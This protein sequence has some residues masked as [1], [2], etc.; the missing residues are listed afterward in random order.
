M[1]STNTALFDRS[2]IV[3]LSELD[4]LP[5]KVVLVAV[6]EA[7]VFEANHIP[8]SVSIEPAEL[9]SGQSPAVG[10]IPS[11]ER[12][13]A[14]FSRIGLSPESHVVAYDDEGG[15]WAGRLIWTLDVIGHGRSSY[16]NGGLV[17][18]LKSGRPVQTGPVTPTPA[19]YRAQLD[20]TRLRDKEWVLAH[21]DDPEVQVWDARSPEE[22][23]GERRNALRNGHIPGARNLDWLEL[24]DP[25]ND[26]RL[27]PPDVIRNKL[28]R[29]GIDADKA[30]VT[31]CQ[32]HHRSGLTWLAGKALGLD[33]QAYDGSWSEWGNDPDTPIETGD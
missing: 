14:L 11:A 33:I 19:P 20:E 9:V 30:L 32:T 15:G 4:N 27:L 16:L 24:M 17:A 31:H 26:L 10:K 2:L 8:G 23:R 25:Y 13:S 21:L 18:W 22:Y 12:L 1:T 7:R 29:H 6:C 3:E 5:G 28:Q